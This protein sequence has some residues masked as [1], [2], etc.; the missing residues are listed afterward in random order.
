MQR[1][2]SRLENNLAVSQSHK[3]RLRSA[4]TGRKMLRSI[5]LPSNSTAPYEVPFFGRAK[6]SG[7]S[8][9]G[10]LWLRAILMALAAGAFV[11]APAHAQL[12]GGIGEPKTIKTNRTEEGLKIDAEIDKEYR[13]KA[14]QHTPDVKA[15]PWSDVRTTP[16][17]PTSK[18]K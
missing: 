18:A 1:S 12:K 4:E 2:A 15:D 3:D 16:A 13:A 9:M 7:E 14:G 8:S 5:A 6:E 11:A 17:K 10:R